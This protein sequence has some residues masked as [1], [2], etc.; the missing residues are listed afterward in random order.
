[1]STKLSPA[2]IDEVRR[3]LRETPLCRRRIRDAS[4]IKANWMS[5]FVRGKGKEP[6][7]STVVKLRQA[8]VSM[9]W[10]SVVNAVGLRDGKETPTSARDVLIHVF[11]DTRGPYWTVGHFRD[12]RWWDS[13]LH[14]EI[15]G[16]VEWL[17]LP[18]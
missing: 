17:E 5:R 9:A 4:C 16:T 18:A 11:A 14:T 10:K 12:G 8:I 3:M 7:P 15:F 13:S 1:M 6:D 2:E